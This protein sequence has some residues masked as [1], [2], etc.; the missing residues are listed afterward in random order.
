GRLL[1]V[2]GSGAEGAADGDF[3]RAT[4]HHPQGLAERDEILYIADTENHLIRAAD[5]RTRKVTTIAGTGHQPQVRGGGGKA[6]DTSISS[7]WDLTFA[8]K[9]LYIAMAGPHQLW[10]LDLDRDKIQPYAGSGREDIID[11]PLK[12]AALAQPSGITTDGAHLYFADSEVSAVRVADTNPA[13]E[14]KTIVGEGLFEFGDRDGAA[15]QARL[16]HPL[17]VLFH[18][19]K[20]YVADSYNHKIKVIDLARGT[21]ASFVGTGKP[22]S[23]DGREGQLSE[24]AGLAAVGDSLYIADTNNQAVRVADLRTGALRTVQIVGLRPPLKSTS[25]AGAPATRPKSSLGPHVQQIKLAARSVKADSSGEIVV[26]V[27]FPAGYH[28]NPEASLSYT[29]IGLEGDAIT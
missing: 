10:V 11:G 25:A 7:P 9:R 6:L 4:L 18:G 8:G 20:L 13:G 5:L 14:V 1:D 23:K 12:S 19:G 15:K 22:G 2:I 3:A 16:Q 17:G 21:V 26:D 27:K 28:L 29:L 24:P